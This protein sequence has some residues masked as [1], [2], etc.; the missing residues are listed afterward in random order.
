MSYRRNNTA[1]TATAT[2]TATYATRAVPVAA[3]AAAAGQR[4]Y[5]VSIDTGSFANVEIVVGDYHHHHHHHHRAGAWART[6]SSVD[7]VKVTSKKGHV[8]AY[9]MP[10][11]VSTADIYLF[12]PATADSFSPSFTRQ[13]NFS[14]YDT[15]DTNDK[16]HAFHIGTTTAC[17]VRALPLVFFRVHV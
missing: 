8:Y 5:I 3:A 10:T 1:A 4:S 11:G 6:P 16:T 13:Q 7:T 14:S 2:A 9:G 17:V 15:N 12:H